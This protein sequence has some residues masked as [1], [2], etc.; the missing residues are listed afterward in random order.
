[1]N[2]TDGHDRDYPLAL[3]F[4]LRAVEMSTDPSAGPGVAAKDTPGGEK[5]RAWWG[6]KLVRSR[7]GLS[8]D[9]G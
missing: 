4:F 1:M 6:V 8:L 9:L 7:H 3:K 5:T 2:N